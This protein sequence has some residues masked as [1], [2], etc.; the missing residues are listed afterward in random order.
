[1]SPG[2]KHDKSLVFLRSL[3][4]E[5]ESTED[6]DDCQGPKKTITNVPTVDVNDDI[7]EAV[8]KL[9]EYPT[10]LPGDVNRDIANVVNVA[11]G[12]ACGRVGCICTMTTEVEDGD[13]DD[14]YYY[15]FTNDEG[16]YSASEDW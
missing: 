8:L 2:Y 4:S 13:D 6:R 11:E 10:C 15:N 16:Y 14:D 12:C 1:M 7:N 3:S 9:T 5:E